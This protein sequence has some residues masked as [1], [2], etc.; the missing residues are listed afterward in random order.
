MTV[1]PAQIAPVEGRSAPRPRALANTHPVPT[2]I[3]SHGSFAGISSAAAIKAIETAGSCS[4]GRAENGTDAW[5]AHATSR[6]RLAK[7][8]SAKQ[9]RALD[10]PHRPLRP[11]KHSIPELEAF[12]PH[13]PRISS[14]KRN[15]SKSALCPRDPSR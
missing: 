10:E 6:S 8:S 7:M 1:A 9:I 12:T 2:A 4:S 15:G 3:E 13:R 5:T 14:V 11:L